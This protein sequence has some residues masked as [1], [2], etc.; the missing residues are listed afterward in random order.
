MMKNF[1]EVFTASRS[2]Q[3]KKRSER[4]LID[5]F[6]DLSHLTMHQQVSLAG[7]V[8]DAEIKITLHTL[9]ALSGMQPVKIFNHSL[10]WLPTN[11]FRPI[12][13]AG[14]INQIEQYRIT[15]DYNLY[16][17]E[18]APQNVSG[19]REN[20]D[21]LR[22][23]PWNMYIKE[24]PEAGKRKA[25]SQSTLVS[26]IVESDPFEFMNKLGYSFSNEYWVK[27]YEFV[28]GNIVVRLFRL[29]VQNG[30]DQGDDPMIIDDDELNYRPLT[31]VDKSG[32][33]A[34]KA[35]IN[36]NQLTDLESISSATSQLEKFQTEMS[37][38]FELKMADRNSFDSRVKNR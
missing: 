38:L 35:Y 10:V 29:C 7:I 12:L 30:G 26:K 11:P 14:E 5:R 21:L 37:G 1:T 31:L 15:T 4:E 9:A 25:T 19:F 33:W 24:V 28:F 36:V 22:T 3:V 8:R 2:P 23:R 13:A 18:K 20:T 34:V 16:S 17:D 6:F 27:G 32:R